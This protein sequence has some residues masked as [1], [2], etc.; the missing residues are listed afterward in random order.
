M[1]T[2]EQNI[3][4]HENFLKLESHIQQLLEKLDIK[5]NQVKELEG[6]LLT[7]FQTHSTPNKNIVE[8]IAK[9]IEHFSFR[10]S[11]NRTAAE[12]VRSLKS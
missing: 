3:E 7:I 4:T 12:V 5:E 1:A 11:T 2:I 9:L 6:K 8:E 10:D